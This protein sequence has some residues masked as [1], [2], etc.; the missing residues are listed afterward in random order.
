MKPLLRW[1]ALGTACL[2]V[3]GTVMVVVWPGTVALPQSEPAVTVT[4]P[5]ASPGDTD[6]SGSDGS[7][8]GTSGSTDNSGSGDTIP[9]T[10]GADDANTGTSV[11]G[12]TNTGTSGGAA[13]G[14]Q[15]SHDDHD[16]GTPVH[17]AEPEHGAGHH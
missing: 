3:V 13:A 2:A 16:H 5:A 14:T 17:P 8:T 10:F 11:S 6:T 7:D 12:D 4:I 9:G 15:D 1:T